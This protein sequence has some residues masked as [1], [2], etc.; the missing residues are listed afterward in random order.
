ML[1]FII[2]GHSAIKGMVPLSPK[3]GLRLSHYALRPQTKAN[4]V[5]VCLQSLIDEEELESIQSAAA[6]VKPQVDAGNY[7]EAWDSW[8]LTLRLIK[9]YTSGIDSY[10]FLVFEKQEL[11]TEKRTLLKNGEFACGF[12]VK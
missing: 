6:R 11:P 3:Y 8:Y 4:T 1:P 5:A 9:Y 7:E 10:N 12:L 2:Y